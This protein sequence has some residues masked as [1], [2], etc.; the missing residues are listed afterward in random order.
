MV[1]TKSRVA[2]FAIGILHSGLMAGEL[3][4]WCRPFILGI[5]LDQRQPIFAD[6]SSKE[7]C[8]LTSVVHNAGVYNGIV[9]AGLFATL[10][11][12]PSALPVQVALL[13]GGIV[14]GVFGA[15][16]LAP[17]TIVQAVLGAIALF[18]VAR[19]RD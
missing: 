2:V 6:M 19:Y 1:W 8:F 17:A 18:I 11:A 15:A 13:S 16:T 12:G 5:V 4:R 3:F 10:W 14:A 7:Y 9:A